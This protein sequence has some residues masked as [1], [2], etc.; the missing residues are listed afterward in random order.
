LAASQV[1]NPGDYLATN[2]GRI[3]EQCPP[4]IPSLARRMAFH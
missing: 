2:I 3:G 4:H 1:K